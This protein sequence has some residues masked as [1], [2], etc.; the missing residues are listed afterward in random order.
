MLPPWQWLRT[1][2]VPISVRCRAL[3]CRQGAR[4]RSELRASL[5]R[6]L[7]KLEQHR[8]IVRGAVSCST[9]RPPPDI[10]VKRRW[11]SPPKA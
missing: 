2:L 9:R 5:E 1:N 4:E 8:G 3:R 7:E 6:A 10:G 11:A